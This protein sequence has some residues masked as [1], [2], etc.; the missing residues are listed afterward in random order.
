L[1]GL[2]LVGDLEEMDG[3]WALEAAFIACCEEF[4]RDASAEEIAN[5]SGS[6]DSKPTALADCM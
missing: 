2:S 5:L 4:V 3:L 1:D 6:Y